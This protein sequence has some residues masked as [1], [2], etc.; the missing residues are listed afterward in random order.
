MQNYMQKV[1]LFCKLTVNSKNK[2]Q[3]C[4]CVLSS[5]LHLNQTIFL[6]E[7]EYDFGDRN[8][9]RVL[10]FAF[11]I[12]NIQKSTFVVGFFENCFALFDLYAAL[13]T[14]NPTERKTYCPQKFRMIRRETVAQPLLC[15]FNY[16]LQKGSW[17]ALR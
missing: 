11:W 5:I 15:E 4:L 1:F 14:R 9:L 8:F 12:R 7:T 3:Y 2:Y 17:V 10:P 6:T 13:L 16:F